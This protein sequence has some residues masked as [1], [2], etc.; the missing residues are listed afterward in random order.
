MLYHKSTV[1]ETEEVS[2]NKGKVSD[3]DIT[4][5]KI[6]DLFISTIYQSRVDSLYKTLFFRL[7]RSF[8]QTALAIF[9]CLHIC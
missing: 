1:F 5:F 7:D 9:L 2:K 6:R 4:G 8:Y 3:L